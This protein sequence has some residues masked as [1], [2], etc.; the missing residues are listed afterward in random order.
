MKTGVKVTVTETYYIERCSECPNC[1]TGPGHPN[2]QIIGTFCCADELPTM[3]ELD[4]YDYTKGVPDWCP[5]K[6]K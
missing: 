4:Q 6:G 2:S 1:G 3:K 5:F